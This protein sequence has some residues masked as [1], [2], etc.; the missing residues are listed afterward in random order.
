MSSTRT[1][2]GSNAPQTQQSADRDVSDQAKDT[3][4]ED[5]EG[6][7]WVKQQGKRSR[8]V[9]SQAICKGGKKVCGQPVVYGKESIQCDLCDEWYHPKCQGLSIEAYRALVDY[10]FIWMCMNCRPSLMDVLKLGKS[11]EE[12][13]E[14]VEKKIMGALNEFSTK[15][16][17]SERVEEKITALEKVVAEGM[18]QQVEVGKS[19]KT[20][21]ELVQSM[22]KLQVEIQ[23]SARELKA[24]VEKKEESERREVNLIVHN[25]PESKSSDPEARK[26]YD[27]DSFSNIAEALLE[28]RNMDVDKIYRLGKKNV[29]ENEEHEPKPRLMLVRLKKK[30]SVEALMSKRWDLRKVGFE[31]VYLS[32]DLSPEER[33]VQKKLRQELAEK[34]R[35]N[36]RIFRGKVVP[37]Q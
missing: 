33:E 24:L 17:T 29:G 18:K 4:N 22:P 37:R 3:E 20:Q 14:A 5:S 34:G 2:L 36:Y 6:G 11:I 9:K 10:D 19:L 27:F 21:S 26:K 12:K 35:D 31:N 28:E 23:K 16:E 1:R 30:E 13:L 8:K 15:P 32:R 25:V 7:E